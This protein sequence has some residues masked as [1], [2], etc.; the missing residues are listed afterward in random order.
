MREK[1]IY[2]NVKLSI[3]KKNWIGQRYTE[4]GEGPIFRPGSSKTKVSSQR[5]RPLP[6]PDIFLKESKAS[7]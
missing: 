4:R 5:E 7:S 3:S 6:L 2:Y 1:Y